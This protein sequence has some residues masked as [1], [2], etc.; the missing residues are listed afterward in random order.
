MCSR[1]ILTHDKKI[2]YIEDRINDVRNKYRNLIYKNIFFFFFKKL[3]L[4][5]S[6]FYQILISLFYLTFF[7]CYKI[8]YF[9][10]LNRGCNYLLLIL[11]IIKTHN[12]EL[13][14]SNSGYEIS[15]KKFKI[16]YQILHFLVEW[17]SIAYF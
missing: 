9:F 14:W 3:L 6:I 13:Y 5:N 4:N 11:F 15:D 12:F 17:N 7:N 1:R 16:L 10:F 8:L 2:N